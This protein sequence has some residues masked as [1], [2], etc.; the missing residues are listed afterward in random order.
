MLWHN[1]S[2]ASVRLVTRPR[3]P[4]LRASR[5]LREIASV[6]T[7]RC[8]W[9]GAD[10]SKQRATQPFT[11]LKVAP[12]GQS[13]QDGDAEPSNSTPHIA[14]L[15][16]RS[17]DSW[18]TGVMTHDAAALLSRVLLALCIVMFTARVFGWAIGRLRQPPVIGEIVAGIALGPSLLGLLPGQLDAKLFPPEVVAHLDI[19]AQLGLILF[20]FLVGLEMDVTLLRGREGA[21]GTI[22]LASVIV[23]FGL[24]A[25]VALFLYPR[26]NSV[27][28]NQVSEVAMVLFLG[29]AMSITAFPVLARIISDREIQGTTVGAIA[30]AAAAICDVIAW[31]L[32]ALVVAVVRGGNPMAVLRIVVLTI[33]FAVAM[34][35]IGRPLGHR[36]ETWYQRCGKLTADMLAVILVGTLISAWVTNQ[37]GIHAIFGAFIFGMILPRDDGLVRDVLARLKQV[38]VLLLLPLFFVITGFGVN[39]AG[40]TAAGWVQLLLI[41]GVATVSKFASAY[42]AARWARLPRRHSV[43]IGVLLN[44]RGLAELVILS[45]GRE[46]GVL[47]GELFSIMVLM[48]LITTALT[49][50]LLDII[51]PAHQI[52]TDEH[53]QSH[54]TEPPG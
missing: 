29:V 48:A 43:A 1:R 11:I 51:Y 52:H 5:E 32:L 13:E 35:T 8:P 4:D 15:G 3:H 38:C 28:G 7:R 44:T 19:L 54:R 22:S 17:H 39:V 49:G 53:T 40:M 18:S 41:V 26:H 2:K 21:V 47:D 46:L 10:A 14:K 30:L 23:P 42:L 20:M 12:D 33:V 37:I 16:V 24:G 25:L 45:V 34:H 9:R 31:M 6:P 36:L 50:P 27:E